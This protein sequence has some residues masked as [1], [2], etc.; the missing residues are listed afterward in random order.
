MVRVIKISRTILF[1]KCHTNRRI[2][3]LID[4]I[5]VH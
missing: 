5:P 3:Y 1:F 4:Q 2:Y